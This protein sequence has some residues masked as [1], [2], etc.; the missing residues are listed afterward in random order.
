MFIQLILQN[1]FSFILIISLI[2]FV[3]EFGH[4]IVARF[5]GVRVE[6]FSIGFGRELFGFTDKKLTRWK[7]CLL[8]LG[9]Y[10]KMFGDRNAASMP[11]AEVIAKMNEEEKKYAF[12]AKNVYQRLAVVAA[13][14]IANFLFTIFIFTII[15]YANGVNAVLPVVDKVLPESAAFVSG[16]KSGDK[17]L[18]I[19]GKKIKD[20]SEIQDVMMLN[21]TAEMKVV[22]ERGKKIIQVNVTPKIQKRNDVFGDEVEIPTFGISASL[23]SNQKLNLFE[24]FVNANKETYRITVMIFKTTADLILGKRDL[25]ELGGPIKIAQYSGKTVEFGAMAVLWFMAMI[26]LNL[27]VMNLLPIP[28]L[29]GGHI[30]YYLIEAIRGKA[31]S[32]KAQQVGFNIGLSFI[33][34]LMIFTTVNDIKNLF[35]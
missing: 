20:F 19:N 21:Q 25:K 23:I 2:V 22:I 16:I 9:G 6:Q 12:V 27:G 1:F 15:F 14:P 5:C 13:G 4:F 32:Q 30:L 31:L 18:E 11:D 29:D 34:A 33:L 28:V 3:H 8:P 7:F 10:V 26:S 17:I 35:H 24:S